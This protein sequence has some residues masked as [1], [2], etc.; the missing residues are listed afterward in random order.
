VR[1]LLRSTQ[2]IITCIIL[3]SICLA[4]DNPLNDPNSGMSQALGVLDV[5]WTF[6]FIFEMIVKLISLG[7]CLHKGSYLRNGWNVLD[8]FIVL[9]SIMGLAKLGPSSA[10]KPMRTIRILRPLR[11]VSRFPELKL[12]VDALMSSV[13][14]TLNVLVISCLFLLIFAV[15]GVNYLKG[16]FNSCVTDDC[17]LIAD[18]DVLGEFL[19]QW[20]DGEAHEPTPYSSLNNATYGAM[21]KTCPGDEAGGSAAWITD[22]RHDSKKILSKEVCDCLCGEDAWQAMASQNFDNVFQAFALLWEITSTEGWTTVMY[23]AVDQRGPGMQ[24]VRDY[25][26]IWVG[27]F[28][29]FMLVGAFFVMELFVGVIIDNFNRIRETKGRVF[30]TEAQ[31]EWAT[32]KAFI[33]KIKPE[34]RL[35]RPDGAM[36]SKCYDFVMPGLNPK[37]DQ[38][39][40]ACIIG[41]SCLMAL[42][43]WTQTDTVSDLIEGGN[44]MFALIFTIE[45]VLKLF[46]LNKRYFNDSW[47][48]F[49]FIIVIG[50][51]S[52]ILLKLITGVNVGPVASIIRMFRIGRLFRLIN[53]AKSLRILFN[54]LLS[55][56]PS[57]VNIGGL[58]F[59]LFFI[60]SIMGVQ[61]FAHIQM[62]GDDMTVH[63]NFHG[64]WEAMINL[65]RF[66]TG[67]NWNG[68]CTP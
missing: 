60:Y 39:I 13:P 17:P 61:L 48:R 18:D 1:H 8:F 42:A 21:F 59:L 5:I 65:F 43:H 32:T 53:S 35:R 58:L 38:T 29:A 51:N 55:S 56:I 40:M 67:E 62:D 4:L 22:E 49:D 54:T 68:S 37:F 27:F 9:I 46:A 63:A 64:F 3:S 41:N 33:M 47:N 2:I 24:H 52:G 19:V 16:T 34:K 31:E 30:M 23:A 14:E 26:T 57:L 10:L 44:Y 7:F 6:I 45:M 50:T 15:F 11:M 28:W 66:S 20:Q 25:N 36:A 12:V